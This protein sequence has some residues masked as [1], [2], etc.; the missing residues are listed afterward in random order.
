MSEKAIREKYGGK[1]DKAINRA[2]RAE[3]PEGNEALDKLAKLSGPAAH[4]SKGARGGEPIPE[5]KA[6]EKQKRV[7]AQLEAKIRKKYGLP[8]E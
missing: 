7:V 6:F 5:V 8:P 3:L 2:I 4:A 1:L